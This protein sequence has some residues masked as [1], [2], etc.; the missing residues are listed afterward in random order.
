MNILIIGTGNMGRGIATRA[1]AGKNT[2]TVYDE[3]GAKARALATEL[4]AA[5][6]GDTRDAIAASDIVV[7]ATPYAGSLEV[8]RRLGAALAG[9]IV[10]DISN[11][12]NDTYSDL[13]TAPGASA[14]EEIRKLLPESVKLVKAFNTTFAG[15]L[16]AGNVAGQSLDVFIAGDDDAAKAT[17]AE[18]VKSGGLNAIDVGPLQRARQLEAL[19]FLGIQL[20]FS[21]N[22]GFATGWKLAL[23]AAA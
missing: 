13:V 17:V 18:F 14:A 6:A 10:V 8:A 11:P 16:V 20:Q 9:K 4:G 5:V 19:G 2:V 21:L 3:D 22:T 7:I 1:L 23:P 12:L 15:T